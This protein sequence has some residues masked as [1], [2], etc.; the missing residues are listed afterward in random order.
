VQRLVRVHERADLDLLVPPVG[1]AGVAGTEVHGLHAVGGEVCDVRPRLLRTHPAGARVQQRLHQRRVGADATRGSVADDLE[2]RAGRDERAE[3]TLRLLLRPIGRVAKAQRGDGTIRNDVV[4]DPGLQARD[5]DRLHEGQSTDVNVAP[6]E[7]NERL[8]TGERMLDRVVCE[9]RP[10][11]MPARTV[12]DELGDEVA[13]ASELHL[14][15]RRLEDDREHGIVNGVTGREEPGQR[16]VLDRE[17]L[18]TEEKEADV[19][20]AVRC[21]GLPD[22]LDR[23]GKPSLHVARAEADDGVGLDVTREVVLSRDG[24]V[25]AREDHERRAVSSSRHEEHGFVDLALE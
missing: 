22:E 19:I 12:E 8:Q 23:D 20:D 14:A 7:R 13:E 2:C 4:R 5:R 25:V 10:C 24:V 3:V 9:P 11:G 1:E 17:L 6:L 15:V 18:A 21:L 16:I